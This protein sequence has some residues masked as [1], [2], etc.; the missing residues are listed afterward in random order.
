M[1]FDDDFVIGHVHVLDIKTGKK[2]YNKTDLISGH[3]NPVN[4]RLVLHDGKWQSF[5]WETEPSETF[6]ELLHRRCRQI[7]DKYPYVTLYF[8]GGVDSETMVRAFIESGVHPDEIV[9]NILKIG[10]QNPLQ[11]LDLAVQKLHHFKQFLPKTKI[12]VN[13]LG[14]DYVLGFLNSYNWWESTF[15]QSIGNLRRFPNHILE[16]LGQGHKNAP[17]TGHITASEKPH[18]VIKEGKYY[19]TSYQGI[20]IAQYADWFY[21]SLDCPELHIKQCH[22]VKNY[23]QKNIPDADGFLSERSQYNE[24]VIKACRYE[25]D[26]S[27]QPAKF[28]GLG[29]DL[30]TDVKNEDSIVYQ[31]MKKDDPELFSKYSYKVL[32]TISAIDKSLLSPR[33]RDVENIPPAHR[34]Y[35]GK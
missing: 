6:K 20:A 21:Y 1:R 29:V 13:E 18:I 8:S 4:L 9:I 23:F 3:S 5:D 31:A 15:N 19:S 26:S 11:D 35:L 25:Y 22:L 27:Y 34:F 2:Y 7:R 17:T 30:F 14:R 28:I 10:N 32:D 33:K 12:T 16:I 24:H